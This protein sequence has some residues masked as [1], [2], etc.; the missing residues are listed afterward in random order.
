MAQGGQCIRRLARL[1]DGHRE[2]GA[3]DDGVAVAELRSEI[4]IDGDA[5]KGFEPVFGDHPGI[6]AG[7]ARDDGD[8]LDR[9]QIE[10]H[11][12]QRDGLFER[13]DVG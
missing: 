3:L 4:D 13:A 6:K 12:R 5:R 11:L 1:A 2:V 7:T 10:V 9:A 8:A